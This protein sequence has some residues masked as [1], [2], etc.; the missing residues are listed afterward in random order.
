MNFTCMTAI[1]LMPIVLIWK[2]H[3]TASVTKDMLE[4]VLRVM[5]LTN[6]LEEQIIVIIL[7]IV[8]ILRVVSIVNVNLVTMV[9]VS[10]VLTLMSVDSHTPPVIQ[11][12]M[13]QVRNQTLIEKNM[14]YVLKMQDAKILLVAIH[15]HV[16]LDG[17]EMVLNA[18]MLMNALI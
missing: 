2:E 18:V 7:P 10:H 15:V 17:K 11:Q 1:G 4:T 14:N 5:M 9:M 3:I 12:L 6:V 16:L 8:E 13:N